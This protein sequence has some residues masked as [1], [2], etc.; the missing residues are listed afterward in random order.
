MAVKDPSVNVYNSAKV[1]SLVKRV[2]GSRKLTHAD[3]P[4]AP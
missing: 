1:E 4:P 2:E 3:N